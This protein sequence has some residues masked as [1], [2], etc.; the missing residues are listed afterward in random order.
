M[1]TR[2]LA[3]VADAEPR[4]VVGPALPVPHGVVVTREDPPGGGP[5]AATA[6][7]LAELPADV[8]TV[9]L[10]AADLPF[11][12]AAAVTVLRHTLTSSE[13]A[14]GV[15]Y[16]DPDGRRQLLCGAWRVAALR[17][18]LAA[19]PSPAGAAM[20]ALLADLTVVELRGAD[21]GTPPWFDCD[22]EAAVD[23]ANAVADD[24][25]RY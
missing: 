18:R 22:T 2:V 6:A 4:V 21:T 7:G 16:V 9:V 19:L 11:L 12:T 17:E 10:L 8:D 25:L 5:V 3:A 24:R 15:L 13:A 20:R 14:D 23:A 1:L